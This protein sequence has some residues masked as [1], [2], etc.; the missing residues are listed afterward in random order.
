MKPRPKKK[1]LTARCDHPNCKRRAKSRR[2]C[3]TCEKLVEAGKAESV[4]TLHACGYH[5]G[6]ILERIKKH[7]LTAHP[8]NILRAMGAALKGEDVFD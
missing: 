7:T 6:N 5:Q 8:V 4:F 1:K 2:E 3:L